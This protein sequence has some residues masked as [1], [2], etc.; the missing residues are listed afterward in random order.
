MR[1]D[2]RLLFHGRFDVNVCLRLPINQYNN[3][4]VFGPLECMCGEGMHGKRIDKE[5]RPRF[6]VVVGIGPPPS[7]LA[8][9]GFSCLIERLKG[10]SPRGGFAVSS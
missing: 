3:Q 4:R 10:G 7:P 6:F 1:P 5:R 9:I 8:K 2:K